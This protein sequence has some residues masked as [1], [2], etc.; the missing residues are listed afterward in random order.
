[1]SAKITIRNKIMASLILLVMIW[2]VIST[3]FFQQMLYSLLVAER[4][5]DPVI[6]SI[7]RR[8]VTIGSG[9]TIA[10][11]LVFHLVAAFIARSL[12]NPLKRLIEG[13]RK[14]GTGALQEKITVQNCDEIG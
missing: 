5:P 3:A 6:K 7:V 11:I 10:G 9:L 13:V 2:G 1:M 14:V 8:F 12:S 4:L